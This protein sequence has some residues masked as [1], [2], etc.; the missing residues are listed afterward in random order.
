MKYEDIYLKEYEHDIADSLYQQLL[1]Q[2]AYYTGAEIKTVCRLA[3]KKFLDEPIETTLRRVGFDW[4]RPARRAAILDLE[5]EGRGG[6]LLD[7]ETGFLFESLELP[8]DH[9]DAPIEEMKQRRNV[10]KKAT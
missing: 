2:S 1:S 6:S 4:N 7:V 10:K 5:K 3:S 8:V 9:S